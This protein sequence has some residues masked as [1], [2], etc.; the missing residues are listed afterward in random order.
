MKTAVA[1]F[2]ERIHSQEKDPACLAFEKAQTALLG[3]V[4]FKMDEE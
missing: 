3:F 1:K 4:A 2:K